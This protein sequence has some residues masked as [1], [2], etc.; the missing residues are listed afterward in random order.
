MVALGFPQEDIGFFAYPDPL[1]SG[2]TAVNVGVG[3]A[4]FIN[5]DTK[6]PEAAKAF[7]EFY[8]RNYANYTGQISGV[9]GEPCAIDGINTMLEA[10]C[11]VIN[12]P[13]TTDKALAVRKT[14]AINIG[15]FVQ[16]YLIADEAQ[17]PGIIE[18]YNAI[19]NAAVAENAALD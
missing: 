12:Q 8:I 7:V 13:G 16:E 1:G 6:Y 4:L 15:T 10:G 19:W 17:L 14:A 9:I 5:K 18:K 11:S 3:D 2:N